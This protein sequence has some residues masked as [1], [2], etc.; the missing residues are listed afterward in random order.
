[1][2]L[3]LQNALTFPAALLQPPYF[4]ASAPAPVN[5][6]M[7]GAVIGH[8]ISHIFDNQ[9][10]LF[11]STGRLRNWWKVAD[12]V[13]FNAVTEKLAAQYDT[14]KPLADLSVNGKQTVGE[15]IGDLAGLSAAYDAYRATFGEREAPAWKGFTGDQQFFLGFAQLWATKR[16]EASIR[17]QLLS[18][19]HPPEEFRVA[20]V[21]NHD[22]WYA[23]FDVKPGDKLYL[24]PANR[25]RIW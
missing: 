2:E 16:T 1:M 4:D 21:R 9:G 14:Y 22:A 24:A 5:Y 3:P 7:V 15:N 13:R 17:Q 18:D 12:Q 19:A 6:G 20:T 11:D 23:A 8:E 25:V 10:S